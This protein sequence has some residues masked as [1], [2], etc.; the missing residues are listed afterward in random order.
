MASCG[1]HN[2]KLC[3]MPFTH[4]VRR[5]LA[6]RRLHQIRQVH[7]PQQG[8][9]GSFRSLP[10][11]L[12]LACG[13]DQLEQVLIL[14]AQFLGLVSPNLPARVGGILGHDNLMHRK[15]CF[16]LGGSRSKQGMAPRLTISSTNRARMISRDDVQQ[17]AHH[18]ADQGQPFGLG[19]V[20]QDIGAPVEMPLF[21]WYIRHRLH[22]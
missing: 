13:P 14:H 21:A 8:L 10:S 6:H 9:A 7:I 4:P 12:S 15:C 18:R 16:S 5:R 1:P 20:V 11:S 19:Q 17:P 2:S 22:W 3:L